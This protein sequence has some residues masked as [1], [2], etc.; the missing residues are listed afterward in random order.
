MDEKKSSWKNVIIYKDSVSSEESG[1]ETLEDGYE[2]AVF[3]M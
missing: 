2:R 3:Y 1:K